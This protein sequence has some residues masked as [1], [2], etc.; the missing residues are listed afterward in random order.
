[1]IEQG[2]HLQLDGLREIVEI[3]TEINLGKRRYSKEEL[4]RALMR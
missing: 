3:A 1:M 4:L 2:D